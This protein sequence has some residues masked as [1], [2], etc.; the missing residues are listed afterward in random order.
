[1]QLGM[2][3]LGRMGGNM[4]KRLAE[5]G[6]ERPARLLAQTDRRRDGLRDQVRFGQRLQRNQPDSFREPIEAVRRRLLGQPCLARAAD[7]GER[8]QA[9]RV[10]HPLDLGQFALAS[11]KTVQALRQVVRE[12]IQRPKRWERV[13]Q[14][15]VPELKDLFG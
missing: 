9:A 15:G 7:S 12:R 5:R 10:Q 14:G 8:Q 1:M 3:G 2:I 11:D 13:G 4:A 6:D